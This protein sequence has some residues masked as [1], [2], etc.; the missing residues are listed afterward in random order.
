MDALKEDLKQII[1]DCGVELT[2]EQLQKCVEKAFNDIK[3]HRENPDLKIEDLSEDDQKILTQGALALSVYRTM[4]EYAAKSM[5]IN[6]DQ[7]SVG[8][9]KTTA[10]LVHLYNAQVD[11]FNELLESSK[12][13]ETPQEE[14][15]ENKE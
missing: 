13:E 1:P 10:D 3:Q 6:G 15:I 8:I 9:D 12:E 14:N 7:A 11:K 4:I 5:E 2:D